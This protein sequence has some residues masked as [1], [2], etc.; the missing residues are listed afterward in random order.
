MLQ[1]QNSQSK[2]VRIRSVFISSNW[3]KLRLFFRYYV[4]R[5]KCSYFY[6]ICKLFR[7]TIHTTVR[8]TY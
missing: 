6:A 5:Y 7:L 8:A 4:T 1:T 2:S 3:R